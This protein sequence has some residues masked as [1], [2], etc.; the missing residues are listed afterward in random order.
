M[1]ARKVHGRGKFP[2][3]LAWLLVPVFTGM[4]LSAQ[5]MD[6]EPGIAKERPLPPGQIRLAELPMD[7]L[8]N[9]QV[10][11]AGERLSNRWSDRD[12]T[13]RTE[14]YFQGPDTTWR[15][16]KKGDPEL[17][18][19]NRKSWRLPTDVVGPVKLRIEDAAAG[20]VLAQL[21]VAILP[22]AGSPATGPFLET[23]LNPSEDFDKIQFRF[24]SASGARKCLPDFQ[25][26]IRFALED[27]DGAPDANG[28]PVLSS[29]VK[30]HFW[31][32]DLKMV[33]Q[34]ESRSIGFL[35][36]KAKSNRVF[37]L[38]ENEYYYSN[39]QDSIARIDIRVGG[40]SIS[41]TPGK[42]VEYVFSKSGKHPIS[43]HCETTSGASWDQA[44]VLE[45]MTVL[46]PEFLAR[47]R[48]TEKITGLPIQS[49][50]SGVTMRTPDEIDSLNQIENNAK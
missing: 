32:P 21:D 12:S 14:V 16:M 29:R 25:R 35:S 6:P 11:V 34:G 33:Q 28:L 8:R 37:F 41:L 36:G 26:I 23:P 2:L 3:L 1:V 46:S 47:Q 7:S 22:P 15:L 31:N 18:G 30:Y 45:V 48:K 38:L 39:F 42:R 40:S 50:I 43:L 10:L 44:A 13:I 5:P 4:P 20:K 9:G 24:G 17:I 27:R 49:K 19:L